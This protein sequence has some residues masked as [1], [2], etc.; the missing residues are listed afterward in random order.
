VIGLSLLALGGAGFLLSRTGTELFPRADAGQFQMYVRLPSGTRIEVTER[1]VAEIEQALIDELG[2]PDPEFPVVERHPDSDLRMLISNIG[3]LMDWP[4]AYT[5]NTGP[6]DAFVLVQLKEDRRDVF[7]LVERLRDRLRHRFPQAEFAFDTG[8]M[9]TAALNFGEPAPIHFQVRGSDLDTLGELGQRV[10]RIVGEAN[11]AE[12]VR[13]LQ[14]TDYPTLDID[15]DRTKAALAGLTVEDIMHNLV[16][17]TNSSINFEPAFWIDESNGNHYFIGAQYPESEHV[18]ADTLLDIPITPESG[19]EPVPLRTV[20]TITRGS[21]P[22]FVSH[23]NIPRVV[24]VYADVTPGHSIGDVVAD[25]EGRLMAAEDLGLIREVDERGDVSFPIGG[26]YEGRGYTL[27]A[28]G[29]VQTMRSSFEQL[30]RGLILAIVLVYLVMVAQ[31]RSFIDPLMILLTI[32]LGFIGV[33]LVLYGTGT[34]LSIQS[35]MGIVMMVGIVV[36]YG[37]ILVH[38]ANQRGEDGVSPRDA[39]VEAARVRLRPV[40][41]TSVTTVLALLPMAIGLGGGEANIPLARAIIGGVLGATA[42]TLFVLPCLYVIMKRPPRTPTVSEPGPS[43][44]AEGAR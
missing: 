6:M 16:T 20:G 35:L 41:M 31:F 39:V 2:E 10:S 14:R 3:V 23:R 24:D 18:S 17:A 12:D 40:L 27:A 38:F 25:M 15:I 29:E 44:V 26:D 36:E 7:A 21:G 28:S 1:T 42:L 34:P 19:G 30:A 5:P 37:I 13:V 22:S 32:P 33:A 11:G 8:G 43:L 9:L 4:A